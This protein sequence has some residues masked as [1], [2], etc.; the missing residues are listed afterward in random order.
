MPNSKTLVHMLTSLRTL[1]TGST[2]SPTPPRLAADRAITSAAPTDE[3]IRYQK[4]SR[5]ILIPGA[6]SPEASDWALGYDSHTVNE[7]S[8]GITLAYGRRF[9]W[10]VL[11]FVH[12]RTG[13][14]FSSSSS[15]RIRW[16]PSSWNRSLT[17]GASLS[18]ESYH[19]YLHTWHAYVGAWSMTII[20]QLPIVGVCT[21]R[22]QCSTREVTRQVHI[23]DQYY[24]RHRS[25]LAMRKTAG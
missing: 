23:H 19:C 11:A 20:G 25:W 2:P 21:V 22:L 8:G 17:K 14:G 7:V 1:L 5:D 24:C 4:S 6:G 13:P 15:C 16:T 12:D 3:R 18:F 9:A 10:I